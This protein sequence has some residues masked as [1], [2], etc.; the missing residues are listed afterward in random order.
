MKRAA[1]ALVLVACGS[2]D[3]GDDDGAG[4]IV[5]IE[6]PPPCNAPNPPI[7]IPNGTHPIARWYC[8]GKDAEFGMPSPCPTIGNLLADA[9]SFDVTIQQSH[10]ATVTFQPTGRTLTGMSSGDFNDSVINFTGPDTIEGVI[11]RCTTTTI[12]GNLTSSGS[13]GLVTWEFR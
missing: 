3:D 13:F 5:P 9:T 2:S 11:Y 8:I 6:T 7:A 10:A 12:A 4:E 1:L